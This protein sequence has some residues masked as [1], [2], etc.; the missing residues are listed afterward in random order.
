MVY[1]D[2]IIKKDEQQS[3]LEKNQFKQDF[4]MKRYSI[5]LSTNAS[6]ITKFIYSCITKLQY[7]TLV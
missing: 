2:D 5:W 7:P 6:A 4:I 3:N 1:Q